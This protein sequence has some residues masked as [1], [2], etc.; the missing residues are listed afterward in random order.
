[1]T[2]FSVWNLQISAQ[3][4]KLGSQDTGMTKAVAKNCGKGLTFV[5][6]IHPNVQPGA[7]FGKSV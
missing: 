2:E 5:H 3:R 1:M 7:H 4:P 6:G